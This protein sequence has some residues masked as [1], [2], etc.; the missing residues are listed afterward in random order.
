M[1]KGSLAGLEGELVM[2]NGKSN[3]AIRIQQL[4]CATVEMNSS[5]VE[6]IA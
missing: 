1:I 2:V 4:G 6:K 5:M 3:I